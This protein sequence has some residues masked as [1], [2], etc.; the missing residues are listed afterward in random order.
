M[1]KVFVLEYDSTYMTVNYTKSKPEHHVRV[2]E[3]FED[4][5][6]EYRVLVGRRDMYDEPSMENVQVYR[7]SLGNAVDMRA[8]L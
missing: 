8:W 5:L 3:K 6:T 7:V 4:V 2:Y 1:K